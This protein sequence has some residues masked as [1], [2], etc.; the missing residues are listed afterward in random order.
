M[1]HSV[2]S[3]LAT[4]ALGSKA[5]FLDLADR[6]VKTFAQNLLLFFVGSATL[7]SV[8]WPQVLGSAALAALVTVLIA[9]TTASA[10]TS[11]NPL[12]DILDRAGRTFAG[13][14]VGA[15]PAVGGLL[16]VDWNSA[17]ILAATAALVSVLTSVGT[18]NLGATKGLPTTAPVIPVAVPVIDPTGSVSHVDGD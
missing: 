1:S 17:L 11:G 6:V 7:L 12:V 4:H 2:P 16:D 3:E 13:T 9:V 8:S 5:F 14:L 18:L 15:I 10:I